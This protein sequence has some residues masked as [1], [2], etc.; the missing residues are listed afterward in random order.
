[1]SLASIPI[2]LQAA[3]TAS[4][5]FELKSF[6]PVSG[7]CINNGG[8]LDTS[9]GKF[10]IKWNDVRKFPSMFIQE[11]RGLTLL[12]DTNAVRVPGVLNVGSTAHLQFIV[13]EWID[14]V[15][16]GP[17]YWETL[18]HQLASLHRHTSKHFGLDHDNYIGSLPQQNSQHDDWCDFFI[19]QRIEPQLKTLTINNARA[20]MMESL[21]KKLSDIFPDERPALLHGDLW[22]GN[23][24]ADE[25]GSPVMIDPAVYYGHREAE[26]AFTQLF[27]GFEGTFYA[28][29]QESFPLPPDHHKRVGLFNIYPLLVHANLFGGSYLSRAFGIIERWA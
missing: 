15:R 18:G 22:S 3:L 26:I 29:Y 16:P 8:Q 24:I 13:M 25:V 12:R 5:N 4:Q 27:G 19:T 6:H 1:M 23:I 11:R 28:A 20:K 14:Q 9:R 21:F 2:E 17:G 10:F 7:G